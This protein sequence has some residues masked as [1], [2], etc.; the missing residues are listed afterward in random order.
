MDK[1]IS[2]EFR[3]SY[4]STG[5]LKRMLLKRVTRYQDAG[6]SVLMQNIQE[7]FRG[8]RKDGGRLEEL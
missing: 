3:V 7:G 8:A 6:V 4:G 5:M 2:R 1:E